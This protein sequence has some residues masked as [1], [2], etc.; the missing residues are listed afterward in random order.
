MNDYQYKMTKF[1]TLTFNSLDVHFPFSIHR[2]LKIYHYN[3]YEK[4]AIL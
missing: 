2:S 3:N 4:L 1:T